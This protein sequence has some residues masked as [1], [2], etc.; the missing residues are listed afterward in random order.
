[1]A[2]RLNKSGETGPLLRTHHCLKAPLHHSVTP[3]PYTAPPT[4][5]KRCPKPHK[6]LVRYTPSVR[7]TPNGWGNVREGYIRTG[8]A[9]NGGPGATCRAASPLIAIR[10]GYAMS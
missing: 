6:Q 8:G 5:Y 10:Y 4:S 2:T 3:I 9:A 7:D 1:M